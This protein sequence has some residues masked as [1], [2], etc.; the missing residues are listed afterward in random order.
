MAQRIFNLL[1]KKLNTEQRQAVDT[2]DGPVIVI[3]G[4]GTG[5]TQILTLRIANI[6][7]KTD[8]P[9]DAILALTFTE[10]AAAACRRRLVDIVGASGYRVHIHTFHGYAN[11]IIKRFPDSFPRIV[12]SRS[13]SD[14]ERISLIQ[15]LVDTVALKTLRPFGNVYFY[16]PA[17]AQKIGE[18][19]REN[20]SSQ[21]FE[22]L[23]KKK[24]KTFESLSD[25]HYKSGAHTGM[26]KGNY[27]QVARRFGRDRELLGLY[28]AYEE[29]LG[30][31]HLYD[32]EDMILEVI[33]A[34]ISD[35]DL[36][37]TLQEE[38]QYVLADEHQDA[39]ESQNR[40]LELLIGFHE[41]PNIF[42]VGDDKQAIFR[43]QGA[44]LDNFLYFKKRYPSAE[45]ITLKKNYRSTQPILDAAY[46]LIEGRGPGSE[47]LSEQRGT[48]EKIRV[49]SLLK[50]ADER[51]YIAREVGRLIKEGVK[52][53]DIAVLYRVNRDAEGMA[54]A[55]S[56]LAIP[57]LI[58]SDQNVLSDLSIRKFLALLSCVAS[59]G[60]DDLLVPVLHIDFLNLPPLSVARF[61]AHSKTHF[62]E[63]LANRMTLR[64]AGIKDTKPFIELAK[65]LEHW[66]RLAHN[67]G[68]LK[69]LDA[70]SEESGL[71]KALLSS[72][73]PEEKIA[74]LS[75][76]YGEAQAVGNANRRVSLGEFLRHIELLEEYHLPLM[77]PQGSNE[78]QGVRLMTAHRAKGLEFEHV[79]IIHAREGHWGSRRERNYF[80]PLGDPTTEHNIED[81]R[82]LFYV[83]LTRAKQEVVITYARQ[84][85]AGLP[86]LPSQYIEEMKSEFLV[87]EELGEIHSI[88]RSTP[89]ASRQ[90][91]D[92]GLV[93]SLF[94]EQ[95]LSATALNNYLECPWRYVYRNL[96]RI[97]EAPQKAFEYGSAVHRA[98]HEFFDVWKEGRNPGAK[99]LT[100]RFRR[101]LQKTSLTEGNYKEALGKGTRALEAYY[102]KWHSTWSR[103][104]LN[105]YRIVALMPVD[106]EGLPYLRMRGDLDKI[107]F[108][109]DGVVIHDYKTGKRKTRAQII[110]SQ[111]PSSWGDYKR[112]LVF[113]N[114]LLDLRSDPSSRKQFGTRTG[115]LEFIEPD[116]RGRSTQEV[117]EL[118]HVD[119]VSLQKL[120]HETA[121]AVWS[122]RFLQGGCGKKECHYCMLQDFMRPAL[123]RKK[124]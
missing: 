90:W 67:S 120:V 115:V 38:C 14:V 124:N 55:L 87:R 12:G 34:L 3:A 35:R 85:D 111:G 1:Y 112:Q 58:E 83:A 109:D 10:S 51:A 113:Y 36:L 86:I 122:L 15:E 121:R 25:L 116:E 27:I 47:L 37:F 78:R 72:S 41:H 20:I 23:L 91:L 117:L 59:Y 53:R 89:I 94:T 82:K 39:N 32:Y 68:L 107:S 100:A 31:R 4:P 48:R 74:A 44:S 30:K 6:L 50:P 93:R 8:I 22:K 13:L 84:N 114:F 61:L 21:D 17:I 9:P 95:G 101:A 69:T 106:I 45:V 18:L 65:N 19:K 33:R 75:A 40:F 119:S 54:E 26:M 80:S 73:Y 2:L 57:N 46:S 7:R 79:Y 5:K 29:A 76:L 103:S 11:E 64:K 71:I 62:F 63:A 108:T 97:P 88:T 81:E 24:L 105:E 43:F 99:G 104:I 118:T 56:S 66:K 98:L 49:V 52:P 110:G 77:V 28:K 102:K 42:V 60:Q 92:E 70:V 16:I 96:L 123:I